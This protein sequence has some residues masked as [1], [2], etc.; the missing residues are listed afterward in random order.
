MANDPT[1][2]QVDDACAEDSH[3]KHNDSYSVM[4]KL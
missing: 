1:E 4:R 3:E 2:Y